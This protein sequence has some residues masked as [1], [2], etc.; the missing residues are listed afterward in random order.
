MSYQPKSRDWYKGNYL[1][2]YWRAMISSFEMTFRQMVADSFIL[3][4]IF[5]QPLIIAVLGL[6][7]LRDKGGDYAIFVV[8]GSGMTG[9]WSIL[10]FGSGNSITSERWYGTLET[11]TAAPTPLPVVVFGK[12]LANVVQSLG[13]MIGSYLLVSLLF[14]Y[15]LTVAQPLPFVI[16]I[17]FTIISFVAFGL[18]IAPLFILNPAVQRF[19]NAMEFPVYMLGGFLFPIALLPGWT[20]PLS[21]LLAPYW[22]ARALHDTSSGAASMS[23]VA[24]SWAMMLLSSVITLFVAAVL[25]RVMLY[26]ARADA[27]LGME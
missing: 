16:S 15:P 17:A 25:F 5:V 24:F 8:I 14:G 23:Q 13:S 12:S 10:L 6:W 9:L 26:K 2:K 7:M 4:G 1:L 11:L 19:Q 21:Y 18:V 27:T 20:T 3:F 22:A